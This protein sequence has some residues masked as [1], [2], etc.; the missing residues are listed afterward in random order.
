MFKSNIDDIKVIDDDQN[1][2]IYILGWCVTDK[3][4]TLKCKINGKR[5]PIDL[6]WIRRE[7]VISLF[8]L[9]LDAKNGF[10][11][12]AKIPRKNEFNQF[13][14]YAKFGLKKEKILD[15][16][17][18][19]LS[20]LYQDTHE[21]K[22]CVDRLLGYK[23]RYYVEGYALQGWN[24]CEHLELIDDTQHS[25]SNDFIRKKRPDVTYHYHLPEKSNLLGFEIFFDGNPNTNYFL[26]FNDESIPLI[27]ENQKMKLSHVPMDQYHIWYQ[28]NK[29]SLTELDRQRETKFNFTPKISVIVAAYNT[30]EQ[31]FKEMI[32]SVLQQTY[33]NWELC[34]ADGSDDN[35]L[36]GILNTLYN[37]SR[38]KYKK[39]QKNYGIS[40]NM[41][42]AIRMTTGEYI[43][44]FDHDD[45]LT[46]NALFEVVKSLQKGNIEFIYSD[47][48]KIVGQTG[49]LKDPHFKPDFNIDLIH[50]Q[51]YICHFLVVRSQ[52]VRDL[53]GF[54]SG[55]DGAQD[56]D[57]VLRAIEKINI[58]AIVHIPKV[59][60]HWRMHEQST[61]SNPESKLYAFEAGKRA[62]TDHL[63]RF[64][65][66]ANVRMGRS[67]GIYD[68]YYE[69]ENEPL[70]S[71]I[72]PNCDHIE[73][74]DRAVKSL[75][76]HS[77]YKNF[78][79]IIVE[80]NSKKEE[81]FIYYEKLKKIDERIHI[82]NW[83]AGFNY[84]AINNYAAK[85]AKGDFLLF[86][87]NDT[88]LL[89]SK[90]LSNMLGY[91]SLP[92]VGAVGARLVYE[93][94]SIQH[95]GVVMG[96]G[97]IAN[98]SFMT[99]DGE[100]GGY[101]NR[102]FTTYDV[103]A[104]TAACMMVQKSI[105]DQVEG[106]DEKFEV[107]YND[108]DLCM[109]IRESG[110]EIVYVPFA[111][112]YHYESKSRGKED[113]EE[114]KARFEKESNQ[115]LKKWSSKIEEDPYY[116]PNFSKIYPGGY[117]LKEWEVYELNER[118]N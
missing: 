2:L 91:C 81:T 74:L 35:K 30:N 84:A 106:F 55:Y 108:I 85:H 75:L 36:E 116:N 104:V 9:P 12:M 72:I 96:L 15:L 100:N 86:L 82:L 40:E 77:E 68:V 8:S 26:K 115:F 16:N 48:D 51:N 46:E 89:D 110:K 62:I 90:S 57:F 102:V 73:D 34:I 7:D 60:Y 99:C 27:Y 59:L 45:L 25:I 24:K 76:L 19:E 32:E 114:K 83:N 66:K 97:G 23:E 61:S 21:L 54:D 67:L 64:G 105:F 58:N 107:A 11:I 71:I 17:S 118:G 5:Q 80:N 50:S 65:L 14:L 44:F 98:H 63:E 112:F 47:E 109:K 38:I 29:P 101:F 93:D 94:G 4:I 39:L 103:S 20:K 79:I 92:Y 70:I 42:E 28:L 43:G 1:F 111:H 13:S 49:Y 3:N 10:E 117:Q 53:H 52:L 37:D 56:F 87:N 22:Y 69:I 78:E 18:Q 88:E 6:T 31:F 113:T 95:A 41:N 33:S